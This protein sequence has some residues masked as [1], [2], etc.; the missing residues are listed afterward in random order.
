MRH[1][2]PDIDSGNPL[3]W[4]NTGN[5]KNERMISKEGKAFAKKVGQIFSEKNI[6]PLVISSPMCRTTE[7][8]NLAFG[9][10]YITDPVLRVLVSD[11]NDR[12]QA[13]L[14]KANKLFIKYRGNRPIVFISHRPNVAALSFELISVTEL[15][16][17]KVE[18]DGEIEVIG[19]LKL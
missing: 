1:A 2:H 8:A 6:S 9:K 14:D 3:Y 15:V 16:V 4:D 7:T 12:A 10:E 5:C 13:F 17:A 11:D 19:I 18:A